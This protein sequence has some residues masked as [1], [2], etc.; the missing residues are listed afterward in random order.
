MG[1]KLI[2]DKHTSSVEIEQ[3]IMEL[4]SQWNNLLTM[5][6]FKLQRLLETNDEL[7]WS[8]RVAGFVSWLDETEKVLESHNYGNDL[9]SVERLKRKQMVRCGMIVLQFNK[10]AFFRISRST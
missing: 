8:R 9:I 4:E 10:Y 2:A 5:S 7:V 1:K 6:D 3:E